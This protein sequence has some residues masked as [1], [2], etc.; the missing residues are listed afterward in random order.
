MRGTATPYPTI[1]YGDEGLTCSRCGLTM[2]RAGTRSAAGRPRGATGATPANEYRSY[3]YHT[4]SSLLGDDSTQ[5][6]PQRQGRPF[7]EEPDRKK[8]GRHEDRRRPHLANAA[9]IAAAIR[10]G[11]R[12]GSSDS[13]RLPKSCP[14]PGI[15]PDLG[16]NSR[17]D[18]HSCGAASRKRAGNGP[19]I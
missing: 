5:R 4:G 2:P 14:I 11:P 13:S 8:S 10:R 7:R 3:P 6:Q 12:P 9:L 1:P 18:G 17:N 19:K 16:R 15:S